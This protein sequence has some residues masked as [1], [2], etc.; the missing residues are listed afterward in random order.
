MPENSPRVG[1]R[2]GVFTIDLR[3][4]SLLRENKAIALPARAFDALLFLVT[5]RDRLVEKDEIVAAVWRD[6]AVTD[7]SLIHAVSVLRRALGDDPT[8][9]AF[10]ETVPRHGYRFIGPV[11]EL[12]SPGATHEAAPNQPVHPWWRRAAVAAAVGVAALGLLL[13]LGHASSPTSVRLDQPAPPGT[14]LASDGVV[15]PSGRHLAFVARDAQTGRSALWVRAL[16]S[17]EPYPLP[18]T[19]AAS[20]PFWSPDG[21]TLG[22]FAGGKLMA[23]DVSGGPARRIADVTGT[24]AGGSWGTRGVILFADSMSGLY[25]VSDSGGPVRQI[26]RPDH[27]ATD[28]W[29]A[30]PQFLPD[31]RHFVYQVVAIDGSRAGVFAGSL[32]SPESVRLLDASAATFAPPG[33]LLYVQHDMLMAE[34]LDLERMVL[35]GRPMLLARGLSTPSLAEGNVVSGSRELLAFREGTRHQQLTQVD[36]SGTERGGAIDTPVALSN[37]RLSPDGGSL[38]AT[39]SVN[40]APGV[41]LVD[42]VRRQ[43]TRLSADGLGSVWAPDGRRIAFTTRGGRDLFVRSPRDGDDAHIV[44]TD[45]FV[46]IVNDWSPDGRQMIYAQIDAETKLDLWSIPASGGTPTPLLKTAFNEAQARI[47]PD[48]RWIAYVTE[49]SGAGEVWVRRYPQ[50]DE[51]RQVSVGGGG[52]PQWRPD[53]S[54]LFY[55]SPDR[56]LMAVD[57]PGA[58]RPAFGSPRRLFQTAIVGGPSDARDSYAVMPDGATFLVYG[59]REATGPAPITM[60]R[61]WAAGLTPFAVAPTREPRSAGAFAIPAFAPR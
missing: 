48:G 10:I 1:F 58:G 39:G 13:Y 22:F 14:S 50:M 17:R 52:Q 41:W 28:P 35:S 60:I 19:T 47:S 44:A 30:W 18:D 6:V 16:A 15:S 57:T 59:A 20:N 7:D 46:K 42:L 37:V 4:R 9:P 29:Y 40:D 26:T 56:A 38:L 21:R 24:P 51:P 33:Y 61:H 8:R 31:S 3:G 43:Q 32:D 27:S 11:E 2:L 5:H 54:E 45:A 49:Q 55:L 25:A 12:A 23:V 53:Q 36:R 34:A